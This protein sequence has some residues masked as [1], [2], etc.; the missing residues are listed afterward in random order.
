MK[1]WNLCRRYQSGTNS[2]KY[3]EIKVCMPELN[4]RLRIWSVCFYLLWNADSGLAASVVV[5]RQHQSTFSNV[6]NT[7]SKHDGKRLNYHAFIHLYVNSCIRV[8]YCII[9]C[10]L[11]AKARKQTLMFAWE[12]RHGQPWGKRAR[13]CVFVV[14]KLPSKSTTVIVFVDTI[15]YSNSDSWS[16]GGTGSLSPWS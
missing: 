6:L 7:C 9:N 12:S 10:K 3:L 4:Q 14:L 2:C 13:F 11:E 5:T 15:W 8:N 1:L 16:I